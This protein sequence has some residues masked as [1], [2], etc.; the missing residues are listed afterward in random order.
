[1]SMHLLVVSRTP[2][3][4]RTATRLGV[5]LLE[6]DAAQSWWA[7][8]SRVEARARY[9]RRLLLPAIALTAL[10]SP[11]PTATTQPVTADT[12]LALVLPTPSLS[13]GVRPHA[14]AGSSTRKGRNSLD[15]HKARFVPPAR[16]KWPWRRRRGEAMQNIAAWCGLCWRRGCERVYQEITT[17]RSPRARAAVREVTHLTQVQVL[18]RPHATRRDGVI[19]PGVSQT[20]ILAAPRGAHT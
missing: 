3:H 8:G 4:A 9:R 11:R 15:S 2:S 10:P 19:P 12:S 14:G 6:E 20:K 13:G 7:G 17:L 5:Q 16:R 18:R 1:M